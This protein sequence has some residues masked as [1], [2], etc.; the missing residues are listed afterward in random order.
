MPNMTARDVLVALTVGYPD[1]PGWISRAAIL[2]DPPS[3][4]PGQV[5]RFYETTVVNFFPE[6]TVRL[7]VK[8]LTRRGKPRRQRRR[9]DLVALVQPHYKCFEPFVAGVEI[10]VDQH[11]LEGDTKLPDYLDYCHL[12]YLAVPRCLEHEALAVVAT[13]QPGAYYAGLLLIED[14]GYV[15][16]AIPPEPFQP[17]D[18][19]LK[20]L[21]A[22]LLIRPFKLAKKDRKTFVQFV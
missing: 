7:P 18:R 20:E 21:Y 8:G 16:A 22:E 1:V 19:C 4:L 17:S 13:L 2:V 10:K 9:L 14:D 6:V 3:V 15:T 12:F 5:A 11:D